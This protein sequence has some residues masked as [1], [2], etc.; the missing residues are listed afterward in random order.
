[1]TKEFISFDKEKDVN[2]KFGSG[3]LTEYSLKQKV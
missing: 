1:M 3:W 2:E